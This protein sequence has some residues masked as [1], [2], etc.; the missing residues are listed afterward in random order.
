MRI[1]SRPRQHLTKHLG[2]ERGCQTRTVPTWRVFCFGM[3]QSLWKRARRGCS[4]ALF[5]GRRA[6]VQT[7]AGAWFFDARERPRNARKGCL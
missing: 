7:A 5:V 4:A 1:G 6:V 2:D 3:G